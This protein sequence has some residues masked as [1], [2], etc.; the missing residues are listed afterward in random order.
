VV[1]DEI[2]FY[3]MGCGFPHGPQFAKESK[4]EGS[5]GRARLRLD[6]FVSLACPADSGGTI[7]TRPL[8]FTGRRMIV[9]CHCPH[10]WLRVELQAEDGTPLPGFSES[11]C[12]PIRADTLRHEVTWKGQSDVSALAGKP[13]RVRLRLGDGEVY[14][15][16]FVE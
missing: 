7:L 13:I 4:W 12:D 11:D 16:G 10:G 14:S 15:F 6:G 8:R 1:G 5:I 3:Y 2:L 9:N